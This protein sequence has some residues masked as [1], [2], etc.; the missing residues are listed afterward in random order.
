[1]NAFEGC[2]LLTRI[3]IPESI[4]SI[5][6]LFYA[7]LCHDWERRPTFEL[8]YDVLEKKFNLISYSQQEIEK[9]SEI[10]EQ[11]QKQISAL[12]KKTWYMQFIR[13]FE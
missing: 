12:I 4:T 7:C 2:S 3:I 6:Q 1:M 11:H 13:I 8:I 10:I 9:V 5:G